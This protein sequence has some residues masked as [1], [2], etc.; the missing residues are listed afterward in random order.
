MLL[1]SS[2]SP[3]NISERIAFDRREEQFLDGDRA[4][5]TLAAYARFCFKNASVRSRASFAD[6]A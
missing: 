1:I 3:S 6:S 5:T 2:H 4:T